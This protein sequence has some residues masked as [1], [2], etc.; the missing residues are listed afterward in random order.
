MILV[1]RLK[2]PNRLRGQN[3]FVLA[4]FL[5]FIFLLGCDQKTQPTIVKFNGATMGTSYHITLVSPPK[6]LSK[7]LVQAE[8]E[9]ILQELNRQMSTYID[10]S[11]I[12]RFNQLPADQWFVVPP[13]FFEVVQ[14]SQSFS[15]LSSGRFD[16]TSGPL[17]E[18]WGFGR[19]FS[20][21]VPAPEEIDLAMQKVGW[22]QLSLDAE[23]NAIKKSS[24][25]LALDVSAVAKGYAVDKIAEWLSKQSVDNFLVEIGGEIRV[26][27]LNQRN[28]SWRIGI[29]SPNLTPGR[30]KQRVYLSNS[31]IATSGDYRNYFEYDG[32][33]YSHTIDP[34]TGYPVKH[35]IASVTVIADTAAGADAL[36]TVLNVMGETDALALARSEKLAVF[37]I[38]HDNQSTD[39]Y[40]TEYTQS[41]AQYLS[42]SNIEGSP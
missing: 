39:N 30:T 4:Q 7:G 34:N 22:Q 21:Q 14:L 41:F 35:N 1:V 6:S 16:I 17:I 36:A 23:R 10:D 42:N 5:L 26:S 37:F 15:A 20:S 31:A 27:G 11:E 38:F 28:M 3:F 32:Q 9:K 33:R 2:S 13:E 24:S 29:E 8:T 40:R 12:M 19:N 25:L 18:L